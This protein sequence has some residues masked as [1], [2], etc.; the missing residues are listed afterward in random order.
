MPREPRMKPS[1][2]IEDI[3]ENFMYTSD[4]DVAPLWGRVYAITRF[5]DEQYEKEE[6]I[7][8]EFCEKHQMFKSNCL[9]WQKEKMLNSC[10]DQ[11]QDNEVEITYKGKV[12]GKISESFTKKKPCNNCG[13]TYQDPNY[14]SVSGRTADK[15]VFEEKSIVIEK[16]CEHHYCLNEPICCKCLEPSNQDQE[17]AK[18][19][20]ERNANPDTLTATIIARE[21]EERLRL[22]RNALIDE[23]IEE[24]NEMYDPDTRSNESRRGYDEAFS[25]FSNLLKSKKK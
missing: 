22:V 4:K 12:L 11:Y 1:E 17:V 2:I 25:H 18:P 16:E 13:T 8:D 15:H 7:E 14:C 23:L 3:Y 24:M 9:K 20:S 5:L 19:V 6:S 10:S 21:G